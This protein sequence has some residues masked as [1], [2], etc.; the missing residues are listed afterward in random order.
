[1]PALKDPFRFLRRHH[2]PGARSHWRLCSG[3]WSERAPA[4]HLRSLRGAGDHAYWAHVGDTRLYFFHGGKLASRTRDHSLVQQLF[5]QGKIT[6][7]R[8]PRIPS[9]TRFTVAWAAPFP[10]ISSCRA[11]CR[12]AKGIPCCLCSD[13][14]WGL[15]ATDEIASILDVYPIATAVLNCSTMPNCVA[16]R[17]GTI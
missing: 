1:M 3:A 12:Y 13:G 11:R 17:M 7:M 8:C 15:L 9:A 4:H 2:Q 10:P 6:R 16:V 5:E 14:L